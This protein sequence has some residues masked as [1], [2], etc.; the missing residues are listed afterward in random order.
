M[1][2][3]NRD[4]QALLEPKRGMTCGFGSEAHGAKVCKDKK[5]GVSAL[6]LFAGYCACCAPK[7]NINVLF[8]GEEA[9]ASTSAEPEKEGNTPSALRSAAC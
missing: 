3:F 9:A 4:V 5:C 7:H 1:D 6:F 8:V 2:N